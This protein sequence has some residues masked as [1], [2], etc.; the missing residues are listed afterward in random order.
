MKISDPLDF[1]S[2]LKALQEVILMMN[3]RNDFIITFFAAFAWIE[4][5][6][7]N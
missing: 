2:F 1:H 6:V 5:D 7:R 3:I 4:K